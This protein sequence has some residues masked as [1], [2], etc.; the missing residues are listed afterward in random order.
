M[1]LENS[2][3]DVIAQK[4]EDGTIER[5]IAEELEKG[6]RKSLEDLFSWR[7]DA[8]KVIEEKIKSVIVPYLKNYDY[9]KYILKLDS[10]LV[11]ILKNTTLDNKKM[12]ENFKELAS[13]ETVKEIEVSEIFDKWM[14]YVAKK[15]NTSNLEVVYGDGVSYENPEVTLE[16]EYS[17]DR[18]WSSFKDAKIIFECEKDE[19]MNVE[20]RLKK[21]R[22][23]N[24]T[25]TSQS[26]HDIS[27]LR[28]L[29]EFQ[30]FLM[31]LAQSGTKIIIDTEY[32]DVEVE[33]ETEPEP[34]FS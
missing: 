23:Y 15:I 28:Y 1:N 20:I 10:V 6:I 13:Y 26:I 34:I 9:S 8:H 21:F 33:V 29:D 32:E 7:G 12:L 19:E 18:S 14:D 16:V 30:I 11:E 3:K 25:I 24:W 31:N 27:S 5:L 17:E 2:I 4:L 22:E